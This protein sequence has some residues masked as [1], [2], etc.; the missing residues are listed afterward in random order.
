MPDTQNPLRDGIRLK[1]TPQPSTL[2]ILGATGDLTK[3]KLVP[4]LYNLF[5]QDLLPP[6]FRIVA[7]ARRD[8]DD[9]IFRNDMEEA[10]KKISWRYKRYE[11]HATLF[12]AHPLSQ[13]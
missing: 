13:R 1:R 8:K 7:F 3:R 12:I 9:D 10:L 4:S 5:L 2:I 6:D 11:Q